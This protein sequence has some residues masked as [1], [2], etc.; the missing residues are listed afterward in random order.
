MVTP[1]YVCV[2]Q[3]AALI[4]LHTVDKNHSIHFHVVKT[5]SCGHRLCLVKSQFIFLVVYNQFLR[6]KAQ[7][8]LQLP[9][10]CSSIRSL[11]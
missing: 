10:A 4:Y 11:I 7:R 6:V 3:K 8:I 1:R 9:A 2:S 5:D